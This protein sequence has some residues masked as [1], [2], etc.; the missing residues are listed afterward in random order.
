MRAKTTRDIAKFIVETGFSQ[1]SPEVVKLTKQVALRHLGMNLAGALLTPG[2]ILIRY[3][4]A[5]GA[6]QEAGILG[7]SLRTTTEI[8][9]LA[10]GTLA[11]A[12]ELEDV[13]FPEGQYTCAVY[14]A[15]FALGEKL[16][17]AGREVIEAIV[18]GHE[19]SARLA[20]AGINAAERG[21]LNAAVWSNLG[22]AAMASKMLK[23]SEE[24]TVM[25]LSLAASQSGGIARQTGTG[26]HLFESGAAGRNGIC[27]AELAKRGLTGNPTI[28]EGRGGLMELVSGAPAFELTDEFRT[29]AVGMKKYPCCFLMHRNIDGV[30]DLIKEHGITLEDV[31]D[32]EVGINETVSMY[33]KYQQPETGEDA[34]FSIPHCVAACFLDGRV[35]LET[36]TDAKARDQKFIEARK[37]VKV[38]VHPE[39]KKGYPPAFVSPLIIRLKDGRVLAKECLYARGQANDRL[40]DAEIMKSFMDC[41][42][43]H[44]ALSRGKAEQ[45]AD[46]AINIEKVKDV[47]EIMTILTFPGNR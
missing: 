9:A 26:A 44:G 42:D 25:A 32:V 30:F 38:V 21:W 47:Y 31:E 24:Q 27:A 6:V 35:F 43:F 17:L 20:L 4:E 8:A 40:S 39:Y 16:R 11:H 12:T 22:V 1:L 3:A 33:L 19:V 41:V 10:N 14:P 45:V 28:L 5:Q 36:F 37:K 7:A 13:G 15:A 18:L 29:L 23:L 46:M 34:R 2:Q